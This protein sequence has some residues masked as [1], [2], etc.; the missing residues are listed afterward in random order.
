MLTNIKNDNHSFLFQLFIYE[1]RNLAASYLEEIGIDKEQINQTDDNGNTLLNN[2]L[3]SLDKNR[4]EK[5]S[6]YKRK[7]ISPLQ[8]KGNIHQREE[9]NDTLYIIEYLINSG[10]D[11]NIK[12][13]FDYNT[14]DLLYIL[15]FWYI[16]DKYNIK[17]ENINHLNVKVFE[18]GLP[19]PIHYVAIM[20]NNTESIDRFIKMDLN[21]DVIDKEGKFS[22][23]YA[24]KLETLEAFIN[25]VNKDNIEDNYSNI[26]K[27]WEYL[28]TS[29][30]LKMSDL[31]SSKVNNNNISKINENNVLI[32]ILSQTSRKKDFNEYLKTNNIN[33]CDYLLD[34]KN[35][36]SDN[37][38]ISLLLTSSLTLINNYIYNTTVLNEIIKK[39][40]NLFYESI[41]GIPDFMFLFINSYVYEVKKKKEKLQTNITKEFFLKSICAYLN[42]QYKI[43]ETL[44]LKDSETL[45]NFIINQTN[46]ILSLDNDNFF[47]KHEILINHLY[48]AL[49]QFLC[50]EIYFKNDKDYYSNNKLNSPLIYSDNYLSLKKGDKYLY[51]IF[52]H[53]LVEICLRRSEFYQYG[54]LKLEHLNQLLSQTRCNS[55]FKDLTYLNSIGVEVGEA[56]LLSI[57]VSKTKLYNNNEVILDILI[58]NNTIDYNE[59]N[60]KILSLILDNNNVDLPLKSRIELLFNVIKEKNI[61]NKKLINTTK[62]HNKKRL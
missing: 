34:I 42:I 48:E 59:K 49:E 41:P 45:L 12:N 1:N 61:I 6:S 57:A 54:N 37:K 19:L 23:Q 40:D 9:G 31:L 7:I 28:E 44:S 52:L 58:N 4:K 51:E 50:D 8:L 32:S 24:K 14:K 47:I 27:S 18:N 26:L 43:N 15:N 35:P 13:M 2:F 38:K 11:L 29:E 56:Y 46:L 33:I 16:I 10:A 39:T 20:K 3:Y 53:L 60:E 36:Y 21:F 22:V 5:S 62:E 55:R 17:H 25:Y 30:L